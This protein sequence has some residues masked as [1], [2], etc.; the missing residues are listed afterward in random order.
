MK[1]LHEMVPYLIFVAFSFRYGIVRSVL[2]HVFMEINTRIWTKLYHF[3]VAR[4]DPAACPSLF[5]YSKADELVTYDA[6]EGVIAQRQKSIGLVA[7]KRWDTSP[8]VRH[9]YDFETEYITELKKFAAT[10]G[11]N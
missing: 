11:M 4:R 2:V 7:Q 9:I 5:L 1:I 8:H 3:Y 10:I 6:V